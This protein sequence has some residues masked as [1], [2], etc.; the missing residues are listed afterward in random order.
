MRI[1]NVSATSNVM[2]FMTDS[3]DHVTGK[4]GL[5]LTVTASKNGAAFASIT[6]TVTE[7]GDGWYNVAL[8]AAHTDTEGDLALHVTSSGAD[9][10]DLICRVSPL[11]QL[12]RNKRV[13]DPA[14]GVE[15][16]Y[17]DSGTALK[18]RNVFEDAAGTQ[19]YRDKGYD[20]VE[21]FT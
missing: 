17:D 14:T 9:P 6:P 4:T 11:E 21:R 7:R 13:L 3:T 19:A 18:T 2:V 16:L 5:T 12:L 1:L 10:S 20:R 15:T 8:T